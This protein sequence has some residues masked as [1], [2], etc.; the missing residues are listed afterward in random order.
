MIR[1]ALTT[2]RALLASTLMLARRD[3]PT[4]L[5]RIMRELLVESGAAATERE[6]KVRLQQSTRIISVVSITAVAL[7]GTL[8]FSE[9]YST[10]QEPL[11]GT[12][13]E[14]EAANVVGGFGD[15]MAFVPIVVIVLLAALVITVV[16]QM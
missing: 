1:N 10:M 7:I 6:A 9:M 12:P 3:G 15:A 2:L 16:R 4:D 11:N 8:I 5:R 13:L 14:T